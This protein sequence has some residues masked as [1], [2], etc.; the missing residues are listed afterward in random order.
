MTFVSVIIDVKLTLD[1]LGHCCC[2]YIGTMASVLQTILYFGDQ[3][4]SWADG[5]DQLYRQA[6]TTSWLQSFLDDLTQVFKEEAKG[7]DRVLHD[8]LGD[9]SSLL[10]LADRY[11]HATDEMGM[12][13]AMLLHALR[14]AMLLQ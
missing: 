9:Y 11:R 13:H 8:S 12:A 4:D 2:P 6:A 3:T 1:D 7:M 14:A 10:E 5:I